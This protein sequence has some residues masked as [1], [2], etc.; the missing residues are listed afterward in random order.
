TRRSWQDLFVSARPAF[1]LA[2][3]ALI[4]FVAWN[5]GRV[6]TGSRLHDSLVDEVVSDHVRSMMGDHLFDVASTNQ[7][8][9]KP[10][11]AGKVDFSPQVVD[12]AD[13]GFPLTGGR[14]DYLAGRPVAALVYGRRQH[15]INLFIWPSAAEESQVKETSDTRRGYHVCHWT[16]GGMT[17]YAV[18]DVNAGDLKEFSRRITESGAASSAPR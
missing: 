13:K 3:F 16:T 14:L 17:Y 9:V 6:S 11:F 8:T 12:L 10:W 7:H 2:A 18:S 1:S 15:I 5:L 4:A